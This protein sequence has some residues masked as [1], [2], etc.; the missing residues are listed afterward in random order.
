MPSSLPSLFFK[1]CTNIHCPSEFLNLRNGANSPSSSCVHRS[2]ANSPV[3]KGDSHFNSFTSFKRF[4]SFCKDS[5]FSATFCTC[6]KRYFWTILALFHTNCPAI[7][8]R[9]I[10]IRLADPIKTSWI[11]ESFVLTSNSSVT[12]AF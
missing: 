2:N 10:T 1:F 8:N 9:F 5:L 4:N 6:W 12:S 11:D 7:V 3:F